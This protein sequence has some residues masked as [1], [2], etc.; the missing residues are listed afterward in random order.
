MKTLISQHTLDSSEKNHV[1]QLLLGHGDKQSARSKGHCPLSKM[2]AKT[3]YI[4]DPCQNHAEFSVEF[5]GGKP[6]SVRHAW[7]AGF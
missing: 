4:K 2:C 3:V 5:G 7:P 6:P 1:P